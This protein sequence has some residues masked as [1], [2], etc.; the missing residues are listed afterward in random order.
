MFNLYFDPSFTYR[1][2]FLTIEG[3]SRINKKMAKYSVD[4]KAN[5]DTWDLYYF[6]K[7]TWT[8]AQD[9]DISAT[10]GY[11]TYNG[12]PKGYNNPRWMCSAS[13]SKSIRGITLSLMADDLLNQNKYR[14]RTNGYNYSEDYNR[15][16]IGR[17][18]MMSLTFNFGKSNAMKSQAAKQS[19][20]NLM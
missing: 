3:G 14:S 6:I 9:L 8:T 5:V 10:I 17:K 11:N 19:L 1:G 7:P 16:C 15:L 4:S 20:W 18:I 2:D 12:Y 13:I